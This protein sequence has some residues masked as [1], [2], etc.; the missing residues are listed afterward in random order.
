MVWLLEQGV[1]V[2]KLPSALAVPA[3]GGPGDHV[4]G[5]HSAHCT[6]PVMLLAPEPAGHWQYSGPLAPGELVKPPLGQRTH[7]ARVPP[8]AYV[9]GSQREQVLPP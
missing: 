1:H 4:P 7:A 6:E 9:P 2:F 8:N 3:A 5:A